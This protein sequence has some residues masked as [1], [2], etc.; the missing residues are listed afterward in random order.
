MKT[1]L[2]TLFALMWQS[3]SFSQT[4]T[5]TSPDGNIAVVVFLED[6]KAHYNASYKGVPM[7]ENSPLG[8]VC[9][10]EDFSSGFTLLSSEIGKIKKEYTLKRAKQSA[11]DYEANQLIVKLE[12]GHGYELEVEFQVSNHNIAFR[13][14]LPVMD[15]IRSC[16]IEKEI[17]GFNLPDKATTFLTPQATPMIGWKR[18][19]PSYEEEYG[20]DE[21]MGTTSKYGVGYTFP[22]LF[23]VGDDGWVLISETGVDSHYCASK[24]SEGTSDGRY[25]IS[26]PEPGENNGLGSSTP[27]FSLPGFT[28]WRTIT[29]GDTL[30]PIVETTIPFDVVEEQYNASQEYKL[31][32][33]TW[34]WIMWQD[35]SMNYAD[36]V[37]YIDLAADMGYEFCLMDALW[38]TQVGYE[39]MED[40]FDYA[41]SKGVHPFVWYNSNGYGNDAPPGPHNRMS[42]SIE[43]KKEM[44]W[45]AGNGVKGIKVDFFGGDKQEVIKLYEDILSDA[46]DYGLMVIFHG[47]T[48]PRGWERM[49]PNYIGSEAVLASENLIFQQHFN[50]QEAFNASLHPFIRNAVGSM[51]FGPVLLNKYHNR[52]NDG[53]TVRRTSVNFQLATAVLFQSPVQMFGIAPNNL[54]DAPAH[55]IEFMKRIPTTWDETCFLTGYPGE[56]VVLARRHGEQWYVA[57]INAQSETIELSLELPMFDGKNVMLY[58]DSEELVSSVTESQVTETGLVNVSIPSNGAVIITSEQ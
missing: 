35:N 32:R 43:R 8:L 6:G 18:S 31:G 30:K 38:D 25:T 47:C 55:A 14:H 53:G 44:K 56:Y 12:N 41:Q 45:L 37:T 10:S 19:K 1:T 26:F 42:R 5:I 15:E 48:L 23:H 33:G 40:L 24:L 52:T 16:R 34:S 22:A 4:K 39:R 58:H 29:M 36:Q 49:F 21:R 9:N 28:P 17:T 2:I 13:Y 7:L 3:I 51:E 57:G 50:D 20:A 54:E 46:N 11:F 27:G